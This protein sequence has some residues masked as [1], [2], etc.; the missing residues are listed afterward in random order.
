[1][2]VTENARLESA[3]AALSSRGYAWIERAFET[4]EHAFGL[5]RALVAECCANDRS[6][7]LSVIGDFVIPPADSGQSRDFQTLHFDF[8]LPL[9]PSAEQDVARYTALHAPKCIGHVSASTRLVALSGLLSQRTWA[10]RPQLVDRL[11]A[12]GRTHG[13]WDDAR[14]YTEGSLAR[15]VEAADGA[16]LTLPSVKVAPDFLC[17]LEFD[18]LPAE[19]EFFARHGLVVEEVEVEVRLRPGNC[20]SSTT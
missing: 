10:S 4:P 6:A 2:S 7:P 8:G 18:S 16:S 20:S 13:A 14:G 19:L 12:Y 11:I 17:G 5:A 1:M 3:R 9:E 15:I